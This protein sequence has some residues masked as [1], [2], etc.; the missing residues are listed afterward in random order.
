MAIKK[1]VAI[2]Y[3]FAFLS[4]YFCSMAYAMLSESINKSYNIDLPQTIV[5]NDT[6]SAISSVSSWGGILITV[7]IIALILTILSV[8]LSS[9]AMGAAM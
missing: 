7:G 8:V 9:K 4:V 2:S 1:Y 6:I 5:M 3:C